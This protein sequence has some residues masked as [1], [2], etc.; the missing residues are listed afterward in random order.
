MF[1]D[2][3]GH[4]FQKNILIRAAREN[5]VSHSYLFVGPDG[6]GKKLV[7]LEFA[8]ILN[9]ND[10]AAAN[11]EACECGSCKKIEKGIHPDVVLVE[12]TGVKNIKV[13]QVREEVEDKLFLKPFEGR[14]KVVIVDESERMNNS[15]Q[16]AF[17]KTLEEPPKDSVIILVTSSPTSLLPTIRSRCQML[18]FNPLGETVIAEMLESRGDYSREEAVLASR[19]SGGSPGKALK[20][21]RE[22]MVWRKEL[23]SA[24]G[25]SSRYS[26]SDITGLADSVSQGSSSDDTERLE[27]AFRFIYL[28]LR[29]LIL[30]KIGSDEVINTDLIEELKRTAASWETGELLEMQKY[31]EKTWYD[32]FRTNANTKLALENLFINLARPPRAA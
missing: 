29:D 18:W 20:L 30:I 17:L 24:L 13:D 28:W 25:E 16:N 5:I 3:A 31:V 15:A 2:I 32:I 6:V 7:A 1:T 8:K 11:G 23:L 22:L 27:L 19:L 10:D 4:E 26:A 14:F 9:C 21:D 12:F